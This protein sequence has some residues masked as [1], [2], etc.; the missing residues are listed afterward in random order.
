MTYT[1]HNFIVK[2]TIITKINIQTPVVMF[3]ILFKNQVS[4]TSFLAFI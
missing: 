2:A 3:Y 1:S 4:V